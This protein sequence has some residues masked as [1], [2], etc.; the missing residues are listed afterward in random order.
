MLFVD[1]PQQVTSRLP[2]EFEVQ[3]A[4]TLWNNPSAAPIPFEQHSVVVFNAS[5]A[6]R[7][8]TSLHITDRPRLAEVLNRRG[9]I[10]Y[11]MT[12]RCERFHITNFLGQLRWL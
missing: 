6:D 8:S 4:A 3:V 5:Y 9:L 1:F 12:E 2:P 10:V 11:F 7:A